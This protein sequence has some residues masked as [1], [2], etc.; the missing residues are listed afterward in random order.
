MH[1]IGGL[2]CLQMTDDHPPYLFWGGNSCQNLRQGNL[3]V[4]RNRKIYYTRNDLQF[5]FY[6]FLIIYSRIFTLTVANCFCIVYYKRAM[7][8]KWEHETDKRA[9]L[10]NGEK[11]ANPVWFREMHDV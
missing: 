10:L 8:Y 6:C 2:I 7:Y 1:L 4:E 3:T 11:E 9:E 5:V